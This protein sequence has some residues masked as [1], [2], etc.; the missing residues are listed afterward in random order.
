MI[1]QLN[2]LT[3]IYR[4]PKIFGGLIMNQEDRLLSLRNATGTSREWIFLG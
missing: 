2:T 1:S 4:I 3:G